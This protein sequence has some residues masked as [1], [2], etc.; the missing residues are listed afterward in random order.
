MADETTDPVEGQAPIDTPPAAENPPADPPADAGASEDA[1][2][3]WAKKE[4]AKARAEAAKY[5]TSLR[6][7]ETRLTGAKTAEEFEAAK[8]EL[9]KSNRALERALVATK[10]G[11]PEALA[12]RLEGSTLEELE[13][14]AAALK[15]LLAPAPPAEP[16]HHPDA[17]GGL[18]PAPDAELA[19]TPAELAKKYGNRHR[20]IF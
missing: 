2:P 9:L 19:M 10:H 6:D 7:A 3:E 17:S 14:D 1:L 11:L 4:L 18:S 12:K 15:A 20:I 13:A 5:R 8:A 16:E